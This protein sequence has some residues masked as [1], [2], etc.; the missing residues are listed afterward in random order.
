MSTT[1]ANG[2]NDSEAPVDILLIGLGS[3]GSVYAFM[4]ERSGK[5]RVTAVARSNYDIYV[6]G[7]VTL[8]T[9]RFGKHVGWKPYRVVKSQAEALEGDVKYAFCLITTKCLPDVN[10]TPNLVRD[11]IDS[12]KI[13]AWALIQNG[14]DVEAD[15]YA[16][17]KHLD[18]PIISGVCWIGIMTSPDGKLIRWANYDTLVTGIFPALAPPSRPQDRSYSEIEQSAL[19]HFNSLLTAGEAKVFAEDRID[20]I[21]FSKNVVNCLWSSIQGLIRAVPACFDP[22]PAHLQA[23]L[24]A[25][26][27]EIVDT[28]FKSGLLYTGMKLYPEYKPM[29][30]AE[31]TAENAYVKILNASVA[32]QKNGDGGH[33]MSLLIDVE[34]GRPF[35]V[36]VITGAVLK[37]AEEQGLSTPLLAYT[38]SLLKGLQNEILRV[39]KIKKPANGSA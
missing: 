13:G 5:A 3:V 21:R 14:L 32:R 9:D 19:E 28:G 26:A 22:L 39:Q 18:T 25:F 34:M 17:V 15:L 30:N 16:A 20:S 12:G 8:D 1:T 2:M 23:P 37:V 6:S 27:R 7:Q 10:P 38:Y 29:G 36:E 33:K 24:R 35:E 11:A 31:E 4:L